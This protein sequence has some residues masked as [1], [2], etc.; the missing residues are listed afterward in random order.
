[1]LIFLSHILHKATSAS[2]CL[3]FLFA[4]LVSCVLFEV[5]SNQNW[6]LFQCTRV[7]TI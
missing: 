4:I 6:L 1:M 3:P 7:D 5:K 2:L